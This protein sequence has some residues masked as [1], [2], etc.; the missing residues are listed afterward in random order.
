[1]KIIFESK[2]YYN[3]IYA[4]QVEIRNRLKYT[5]LSDDQYDILEEIST[6][7]VEELNN[8]NLRHYWTD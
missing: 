5:E 8:R 7:I 3:A 2:E 4:I 6:F 1:M